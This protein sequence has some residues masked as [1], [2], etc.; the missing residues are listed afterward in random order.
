MLVTVP[1]ASGNCCDCQAVPVLISTL[2]AVP[3]ATELTGLVP[4]PTTKALVGMLVTP[5]PP[6]TTLN[7]VVSPDNDVIS[8]LLPDA[9]ANKLVLAPAAVLA[10]VPPD[11]IAMGAMPVI[12]PPVIVTASE[13]CSAI[14]PTLAVAPEPSPRLVLAPAAVLAPVPPDAIG[15]IAV[16]DNVP[17]VLI[18]TP[19]VVL[20]KLS[21]PILDTLPPVIE[22]AL[23]S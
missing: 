14:V 5:V 20:F 1:P 15:S 13:F 18:T 16:A 6:N 10:P 17:P 12:E 23:A 22:T 7:G 9:A 11:A 4:L 19:V 8:E 21:V 3:G 2:P